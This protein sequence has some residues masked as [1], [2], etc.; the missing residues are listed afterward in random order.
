MKS[1][2]LIFVLTI[3]FSDA[4]AQFYYKDHLLP[5]QTADQIQKYRQHQIRS[6]TAISAENNPQAEGSTLQVKQTI[7]GNYSQLLTITAS[8]VTGES[9]L[10]TWLNEKGLAIKTI[11][12]TDG[13]G[14]TTT[15][16]FNDRNTVEKIVNV[17]SSP[18]HATEKEEHHWFYRNEGKPIRMWK[19][20]NDN[21]TTHVTFEFDEKGNVIE[22][23]ST[24]FGKALTT[25][26][27]Y[28]DDQNRL[29]DIVRYNPIAKR[30]LP[31]YIF[32]YNSNGQLRSM[33]VVPASGSDYHRWMYTYDERGLK[34]KETVLNKNRQVIGTVEYKYE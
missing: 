34:T 20:R 10:T 27:Y 19:I 29:T 33:M 3:I 15:Y 1:F 32:E 24:R 8:P 12:T 7:N 21:D 18:G 6:V 23:K 5:R 9:S 22:E 31:D 4:V 13:A 11:D 26:Y 2:S 30:L 28:Y 25:V 16:V 14:S 17:T